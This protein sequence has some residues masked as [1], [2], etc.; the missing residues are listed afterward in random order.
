M[1]IVEGACGRGSLLD[2]VLLEGKEGDSGWEL[3]DV[4]GGESCFCPRFWENSFQETKL[5]W[6]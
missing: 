3:D 1:S 5:F 6:K 4:V 2:G